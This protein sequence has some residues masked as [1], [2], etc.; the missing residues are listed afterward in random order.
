MSTLESKFDDESMR[1]YREAA[2]KVFAVNFSLKHQALRSLHVLW[3]VSRIPL[4]KT[5][6]LLATGRLL[7]LNTACTAFDT[8]EV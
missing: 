2:R 5:N 3:T 6:A 8:F 4:R 1:N 7:N